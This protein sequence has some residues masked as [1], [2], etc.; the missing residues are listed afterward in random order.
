MKILFI[1]LMIFIGCFF[2]LYIGYL[3]KIIRKHK[4]DKTKSAMFLITT[5]LNGMMVSLLIAFIG[6]SNFNIQIA[7]GVL[8]IKSLS[9]AFVY[10]MALNSLFKEIWKLFY[11]R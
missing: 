3:S 2:Q 5:L 8:Y 1:Y 7:E 6:L 4:V 10:G 9:L 11:K